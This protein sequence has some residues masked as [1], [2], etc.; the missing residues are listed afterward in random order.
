ML[1]KNHEIMGLMKKLIVITVRVSFMPRKL[2][3]ISLARVRLGR[4]SREAES[5]SGGH[6][7]S[8][9][10]KGFLLSKGNWNKSNERKNTLSLFNTNVRKLYFWGKKVSVPTV[11]TVSFLIFSLKKVIK[12]TV[13][14]TEGLGWCNC[15][16][17]YQL[18]LFRSF[19]YLFC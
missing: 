3:T 17:V 7:Q 2:L 18:Y 8:T 11:S 15:I 13:C 9:S 6:G 10:S 16:F 4:A 1:T 12:S 19:L 5:P 14:T